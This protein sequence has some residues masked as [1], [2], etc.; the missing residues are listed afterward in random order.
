MGALALV[1]ISSGARQMPWK[2][3]GIKCRSNSPALPS[4][5]ADARDNRKVNRSTGS[6]S[7]NTRSEVSAGPR[8]AASSA[9]CGASARRSTRNTSLSAGDA[10]CLG[11]AKKQAKD[12]EACRCCGGMHATN[13]VPQKVTAAAA[14]GLHQ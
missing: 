9:S 2:R 14:A 6:P 13:S 10:Q 1:A 3:T 4:M 12:S 5:D 7:L 8:A 11:H